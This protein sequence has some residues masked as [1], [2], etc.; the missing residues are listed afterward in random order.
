M[1]IRV[2]ENLIESVITGQ[3]VE[4]LDIKVGSEVTAVIKSTEVMLMC[5]LTSAVLNEGFTLAP[6]VLRPNR[7]IPASHSSSISS[8]L[9]WMLAVTLFPVLP[10]FTSARNLSKQRG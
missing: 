2:G 6:M 4:K 9:R 8:G 1:G 10:T 7:W 5:R 3:S